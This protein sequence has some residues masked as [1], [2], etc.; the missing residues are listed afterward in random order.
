[1]PQPTGEFGAT[2]AVLWIPEM[3]PT[4]VEVA[5]F[6]AEGDP[7]GVRLTLALR[8]Y[9]PGCRAS[10]FRSTTDD[11]SSRQRI[12]PEPLDFA[13]SQFVYVDES[14]L[15]GVVYHYWIQ[16]HESDGTSFMN[17]PIAAEARVTGPAM[18]LANPAR[19]N[20]VVNRA[21]FEYA[22]GADV[23]GKG[24]VDVSLV[25][26]DL[27]GRALRTLKHA[28]EGMGEYRVEWDATDDAGMR[29]APGV[30]YL[31]LRAGGI[32]RTTKVAVVK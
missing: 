22:I 29:A 7:Q 17:G 13:G 27:Q 9:E 19:P 26:H 28:R 31:K 15:P 12:T 8:N 2:P 11:F 20:P 25:L 5:T 10:V 3:N 30:Y 32:S 21:I 16:V 24:P 18:T 6:Y 1:M 4:A 14:A 23:A